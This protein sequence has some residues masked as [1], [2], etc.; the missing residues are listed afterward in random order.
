VNDPDIAAVRSLAGHYDTTESQ[1]IA[2]LL[3]RVADKLQAANELESRTVP[4]AVDVGVVP[5]PPHFDLSDADGFPLLG[6]VCISC[7]ED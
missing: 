7:G 4:P 3:R 6:R 5:S 1:P 2:I